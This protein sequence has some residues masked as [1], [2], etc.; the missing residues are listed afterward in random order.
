MSFTSLL[1]KHQLSGYAL[2]KRSGISQSTIASWVNGARDP[3]GMSLKNAIKICETLDIDLN[4]LYKE[5]IN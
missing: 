4:T 3:M 1:T 2:S 5:L